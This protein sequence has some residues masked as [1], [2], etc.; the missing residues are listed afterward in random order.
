LDVHFEMALLYKQSGRQDLARKFFE[1]SRSEL[2]QVLSEMPERLKANYLRDRKL[3][4]I[5]SE[6]EN[7]M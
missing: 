7:L 5:H 6:L 4:R 3:E 2:E 1:L